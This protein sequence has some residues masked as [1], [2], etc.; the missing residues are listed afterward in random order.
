VGRV[1]GIAN[2][3]ANVAIEPLTPALHLLDLRPHQTEYMEKLALTMKALR[4]TSMFLHKGYQS[5]RLVILRASPL[6]YPLQQ[7]QVLDAAPTCFL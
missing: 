6:P 2:V 1:L 4:L 5:G 3:G 7:R